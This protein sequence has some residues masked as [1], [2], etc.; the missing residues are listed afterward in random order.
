MQIVFEKPLSSYSGAFLIFWWAMLISCVALCGKG[1]AKSQA[2]ARIEGMLFWIFGAIMIIFAAFRP[3]GIARDD[4]AYLDIYNAVICPTLTCD[5]WIQGSRDWAWYSFVGLLKNW[6]PAPRLMLTIAALALFVKLLVIFR[7]S[8]TPLMAMLL[9]TGVFYQVQDLTAFRASLSLAFLMLAISVWMA[10]SGVVGSVAFCFPG[11]AHKQGFLSI[12]LIFS[13]LFK[14]SLGFLLIVVIVPFAMLWILGKP[15]L[16]SWLNNQ[17]SVLGIPMI[18]Y[19]LDAYLTAQSISVFKEDKLVPIIFYP[20]VGLGL[21]L[22]KDVFQVNRKLY[23]LVACSISLACWLM[24]LFAATTPAQARF[25]EYFM[26][27]IVLLAGCANRT[28]L[29]LALIAIVSGV[30]VVRHNILHPLI[31]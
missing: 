14:R 9:F 15:A 29:N 24:W 7:L 4:Q 17:D 18:Q 27:P 21:W 10:N 30:W 12:L 31:V 16:P 13:P 20:L 25:F 5:Q 3:I 23:S 6:T 28:W 11:L 2:C 26:L 8:R 19:G 22:A 1:E